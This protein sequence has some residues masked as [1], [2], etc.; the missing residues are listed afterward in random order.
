MEAAGELAQ[1][2]SARASSSPAS[3]SAARAAAGSD[4]SFVSASRRDK[5]D[6]DQALLGAVVEI[7]LEAASLDVTRRDNPCSRRGELLEAGLEFCVQ[8]MDLRL[9]CLSFGDVRVGD[10][11]AETTAESVSDRSG[12]DRDVDERSVLALTHGFV[13]VQRLARL[14]S[15][16]QLLALGALRAA[17]PRVVRPGR[18]SP[19]VTSRRCARRPSSTTERACPGRTPRARA[20]RNRS[21]PAAVP[22]AAFFRRCRCRRRRGPPCGPSRPERARRPIITSK[23]VPSFRRRTVW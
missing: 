16:E 19:R 9:L 11:V 13:V 14:N 18:A 21:A 5:R 2:S 17:A 1:A 3:A 20:A 12:C 8:P 22:P 15:R 7:A 10:H 6:R 23:S 4:S